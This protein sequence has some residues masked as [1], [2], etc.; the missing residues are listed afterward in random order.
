MSD[1]RRYTQDN[2][3]RKG[4]FSVRFAVQIPEE[5]SC[6]EVRECAPLMR[7]LRALLYALRDKTSLKISAFVDVW[8]PV[9][10]DADEADEDGEAEDDGEDDGEAVEQA[11][12]S[13]E[14]EFVVFNK[15]S[16]RS[17]RKLQRFLD[18]H[19]RGT[20]NSHLVLV[21]AESSEKFDASRFTVQYLFTDFIA[22]APRRN[23]DDLAQL[24]SQ[25]DRGYA[26]LSR[27]A[28]LYRFRGATYRLWR[29][30]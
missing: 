2:F 1:E 23:W 11:D 20:T 6:G 29:S 21:D 24:L 8:R 25:P 27:T 15:L 3:Y 12:G 13:A 9:E 28:G 16:S 7:A 22:D 18:E 4:Q 19:M 14:A 10:T 26:E 5:V 30:A 17:I